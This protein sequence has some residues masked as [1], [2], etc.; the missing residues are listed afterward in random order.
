MFYKY[1]NMLNIIL[2]R[3][4]G[5]CPELQIFKDLQGCQMFNSYVTHYYRY[6]INYVILCICTYYTCLI[7]H[8]NIL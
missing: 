3:D 4:F 5:C 8:Y 6:K 1:E 7:I 2:S